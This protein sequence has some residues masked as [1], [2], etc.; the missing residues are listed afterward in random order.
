MASGH[1]GRHLCVT[2]G[3]E[4][5]RKGSQG[6]E[7]KSVKIEPKMQVVAPGLEIAM[8]PASRC[9]SNRIIEGSGWTVMAGHIFFRTCVVLSYQ[10]LCAQS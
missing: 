7:K 9:R 8:V 5:K 2:A 1:G 3:F 10:N 6:E 4:A